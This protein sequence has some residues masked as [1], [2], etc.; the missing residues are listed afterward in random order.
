MNSHEI[1]RRGA[2]APVTRFLGPGPWQGWTAI[3]AAGGCQLQEAV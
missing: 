1:P 3:P 2:G